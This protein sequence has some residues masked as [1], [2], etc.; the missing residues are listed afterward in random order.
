MLSGPYLGPCVDSNDSITSANADGDDNDTGTYTAGICAVA[1]DDEDGVTFT[2]PLA[3]GDGS[4]GV[5]VVVGNE[6]CTLNAWIDFDGDGTFEA[7]E[8]IFTDQALAN[9]DNDLTFSIP[10]AAVLG[11]TFARFRCSTNT[12]LCPT[13]S[14]SDGE[15]EDYQVTIDVSEPDTDGDGVPDT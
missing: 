11:T 1:G 9:G 13:G 8:Q 4:A 6:T 15:V 2:T 12:G 3:Q 5:N 7:S 14:T 10:G